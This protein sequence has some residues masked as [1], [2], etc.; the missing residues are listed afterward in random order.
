M[1]NHKLP[2]IAKISSLLR[3][4]VGKPVDCKEKKGGKPNGQVLW[5]HYTSEQGDRE[6]YWIWEFAPGVSVGAAL[7]MVP[8]GEANSTIKK[9]QVDEV[10]LDNFREVCSV[11]V[12][13]LNGDGE[14]A[15]F[16]REVGSEDYKKGP[17][18]EKARALE[19]VVCQLAIEGYASGLI[20]IART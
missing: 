20:Q 3:D 17:M 13:V 12:Q 16:L 19:S 7:T 14:S 2:S 9:G 4:L 6:G 18:S 15:L 8:A 1:T 11:L 10:T 5:A